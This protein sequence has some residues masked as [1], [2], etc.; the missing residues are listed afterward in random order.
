[1]A[2]PRRLYRNVAAESGHLLTVKTPTISVGAFACRILHFLPCKQI[3]P[4]AQAWPL[5]ASILFLPKKSG[6]L[7]ANFAILGMMHFDPP[8]KTTCMIVLPFPAHLTLAP[9]K[10][11]LRSRS[12]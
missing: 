5:H 7:P 8:G 4:F 12:P 11:A 3:Q 6:R 10:T 2:K 1:M 9:A